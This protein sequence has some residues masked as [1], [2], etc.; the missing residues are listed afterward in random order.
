MDNKIK[1]FFE[2]DDLVIP[3]DKVMYVGK[4]RGDGKELFINVT[5]LEGHERRFHTKGKDRDEFY[6]DYIVWLKSK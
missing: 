4:Q 5:M 3:F 2:N 6:N 1:S